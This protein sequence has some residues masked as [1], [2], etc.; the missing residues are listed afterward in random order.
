MLEGHCPTPSCSQEQDGAW[1]SVVAHPKR[2]SK[3]LSTPAEMATVPSAVSEARKKVKLSAPRSAAV[4][5]KLQQ[6]AADRGVTYAGILKKARDN[7][8]LADLGVTE[9]RI[10]ETATGARIIEIPG[11]QSAEKASQLAEKLRNV[12]AEEVRV[13]TPV[14]RAALR[15]V[16]L[17]DSVSVQEIIAAIAAKGEC[18]VDVIKASALVRGQGGN[19]IVFVQCPVTAAKKVTEGRLLVGW[20]SAHIQVIE[21]GPLR[22]YKCLGLGHISV[23]CPSDVDRSTLCF[24][25]GKNGHQSA[26]CTA[27]VAHCAVCGDAG[28]PADHIMR[29]RKCNPPIV[30]AKMVHLARGISTVDQALPREA[31]INHCARAQDL[32]L[33][34]RAEW[35]IDITVVSEPYFVPS[36]SHWLEDLSGLVCIIARPGG[37]PLILK[38]RGI[39]YLVAEWNGLIIVAVYFSPNRE[40][41]EFLTFL[42]NLCLPIQ[43]AQ[44]PVIVLGDFN[45]RS[46]TWG[47]S[48]TNDRGKAVEEWYT[49]LGLFLH[50]RGNVPTCVRAQGQSLVDLTFSSPSLASSVQN[51]KVA[52]DIETLSDHR[53]IRFNIFKSQ[54]RYEVGVNRQAFPRWVLSSLNKDLAEEAA[55]VQAWCAPAIWPTDVNEAASRLRHAAK[56]ISNASMSKWRRQ[57]PRRMVHWWNENI[58]YLREMC[59]SARRA[60]LRN[61]RRHRRDAAQ[62]QRLHSQFVE[63]K[64]ALQLAISQAKDKAHSEFLESLNQ[65][66]WGRPYRLVRNKLQA[67]GPSLTETLRSDFVARIVSELFPADPNIVPPRMTSDI[68]PEIEGEIPLVSDVEFANVVDRLKKRRRAPGPD[69][70]HGRVLAIAVEYLEGEMRESFNLCFCTGQFPQLWKEGRLCLLRK[71]GRPQDTSSAYR[72]I[73]LLNEV[74]KLLERIIVWRLSQHISVV[75]PDLA[76]AQYGFRVGRS[77]LEAIGALKHFTMEAVRSGGKALAVSLDISNAFNSLPFTVIMEALRFHGVPLYLQNLVRSYLEDRKILYVNDSGELVRWPMKCG[78]PQGSVLG[79]LLWNIGYD[80]V[81]RGTLLPKLKM[82]CYADDTL[83]VAQGRDFQEVVR[84]VE[85]GTSLVVD[86]IGLLG[87]KVAL[88]KTSALLFHGP[89]GGPPSRASIIVNEVRVSVGRNMKYLGLILDGRWKFEDHFKAL[90]SR[91]VGAAG[92]LSRLLPNIGGPDER[93]RRLYCGVIRSMALY[94]APVWQDSLTLTNKILLRRPQRVVAR[95]I[96]RCY[97]TVSFTACCILAGTPPWELEAEALTLVYNHRMESRA[98]GIYP[99]VEEVENLRRLARSAT[100]QKWYQDLAN[101]AAGHRTVEAIRPVLSD[102]ANRK[103]GALTFRLVQVLTGHGCFGRYLHDIV[104]REP[105]PSCLECGANDDTAQHTL[106]DCPQWSQLRHNLSSVVGN[107]LALPCKETAERERE[108]FRM[109]PR[110]RRRGVNR[111]R[112]ADLLPPM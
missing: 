64:K 22:C 47:D 59:N 82:F 67:G 108:R 102:W 85:V 45:A 12:L 66:P 7:V 57:P 110:G 20:S 23:K 58:A 5:I 94:G 86:R 28:K 16:G 71:P 52:E 8:V 98:E 68:R 78:V 17:D 95:R 70:I 50:N 4:V 41:S 11:T 49:E 100:M 31:N 107:N 75:G 18:E 73:V 81:L 92:A 15:I 72:P 44:L 42:D 77:T 30:K 69:G 10:R 60:Y 9:V 24:R 36:P 35:D 51:W 101:P 76:D 27:A 19:N 37:Y 111:R 3:I 105:T 90:G 53:Y 1:T 87:L 13:E 32:L 26:T 46:Q 48:L 43:R 74:G 109:N 106:E 39:G 61:R 97:R 21:D 34:T 89:R 112:Y 54:I 6:E 14:K 55:I 38:D 79:P 91:L 62:E 65:D 25:C 84:L 93:C 103:S 33:Q 96:V 40:L 88:E 29:G 2:K 63:H 104:R 56:A 99:G 80:W 83:I